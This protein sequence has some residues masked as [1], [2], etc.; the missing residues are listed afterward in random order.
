MRCNKKWCKGICSVM[1]GDDFTIIK[2]HSPDC[3]PDKLLEAKVKMHD[4]LKLGVRRAPFK[5]LRDTFNEIKSRCV[6]PDN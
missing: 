2:N 4:E 1:K 5:S 3:I 6:A